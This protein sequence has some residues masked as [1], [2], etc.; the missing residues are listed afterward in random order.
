[1][2]LLRKRNLL[3][4]IAGTE[5]ERYI[6]PQLV[7]AVPKEQED[8]HITRKNYSIELHVPATPQDTNVKISATTVP[9]N[10]LIFVHVYM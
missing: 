4:D 1:M 6:I 10:F 7:E 8:R 9:F 3:G 5:V 2:G